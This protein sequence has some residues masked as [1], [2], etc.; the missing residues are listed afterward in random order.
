M[1]IIRME[2]LPVSLAVQFAA[3]DEYEHETEVC[4]DYENGVLSLSVWKGEFLVSQ[5]SV[6]P[7]ELLDKACDEVDCELITG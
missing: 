2:N 4:M 3:E 7:Q 5:M 1:K 6:N